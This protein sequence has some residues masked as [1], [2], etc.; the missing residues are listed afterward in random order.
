MHLFQDDI[1][2]V[3]A[4]FDTYQELAAK[5]AIYP[6]NMD[7]L[8]P[9]LGL[10]EAGEIQNKVKKIYRDG[11]ELTPELRESIAA[12]IGDLLWYCAILAR[13]LGVSFGWVAEQNLRKL[14]SRHD[15]GVIGGAG[16]NR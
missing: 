1:D 8:Y 3:D 2:N 7:I 11:L 14:E 13:D 15:R 6:N 12:E 10:G 9:A 16:D 4:G 5:T